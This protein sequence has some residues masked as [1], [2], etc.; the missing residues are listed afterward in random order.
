MRSTALT[1]IILSALFFSCETVTV[2]TEF[3]ESLPEE[4]ASSLM[5]SGGG[6][7]TNPISRPSEADND[8]QEQMLIK[9]AT[10]RFEVNDYVEARKK[11]GN[12]AEEYE[13]Y[14]SSERKTKSIYRISNTMQI[15]VVSGQF[16]SL[17]DSLLGQSN[18]IDE[19]NITVED[20]TEEYVDVNARLKS[21]KHVENRYLEILDKAQNVS[22]ILEIEQKLGQ[23]REEIE[24]KEARLKYLTHQVSFSTINMT[25]YQNKTV[26]KE[27]GP[28]YLK[29]LSVSF[30]SGWNGFTEFS[31][32]LVSIWPFLLIVT[33]MVYAGFKSAKRNRLK[34]NSC[35]LV[36]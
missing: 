1:I 16:G 35:D 4:R 24:S 21:K 30:L 13:A 31:L 28:G 15:R 23:I 12:I 32:R 36:D 20:V 25:F 11:I 22:E 9:R 6:A 33:G 14:I 18:T 5:T 29:N 34:K 10:L 2:A 17:V 7:G 3:H 27:T 26:T 19:K 8:V